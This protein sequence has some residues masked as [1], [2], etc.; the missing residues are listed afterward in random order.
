MELVNVTPLLLRQSSATVLRQG[1]GSGAEA[2]QPNAS[3]SVLVQ[4]RTD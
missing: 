1:G 2:A 4:L 3:F